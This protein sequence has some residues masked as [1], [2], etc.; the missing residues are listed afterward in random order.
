MITFSVDL[1]QFSGACQRLSGAFYCLALCPD[2]RNVTVYIVKRNIYYVVGLLAVQPLAYGARLLLSAAL[3]PLSLPRLVPNL[4]TELASHL[5]RRVCTAHG[6]R[7]RGLERR[8]LTGGSKQEFLR[9]ALPFIS[10]LQVI[11]D[12]SNLICGWT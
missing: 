10:S 4:P 8:S 12:I 7:A 9:L 6:A 11:V 5:Q 2:N 1:Q 3:G